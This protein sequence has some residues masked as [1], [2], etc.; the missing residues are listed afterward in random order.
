MQDKSTTHEEI[1]T[2]DVDAHIKPNGDIF[3][4]NHRYFGKDVDIVNLIDPEIKYDRKILHFKDGLHKIISCN[5]EKFRIPVPR[6]KPK[7]DFWGD[8]EEL[9]GEEKEE[10][11]GSREEKREEP[12][13]RE[14]NLR[15]AQQRVEQLVLLNDY[16]H[17]L[18]IT[19]NEGTDARNVKEV[20]RK[21]N[22][23]LRD[24]VLRYGLQ[25]VLI[26]EHHKD[27]RIHA[28]A[29]INDKLPLTDSG[30]R[31]VEG[32]KKPVK[33]ETIH[34]KCISEEKIRC[35]VYNVPSWKHGF[36]TAIPVYG[37]RLVLA[38]YITKYVTKGT[39]KIFGRYYWCSRNQEMYPATEY[40][41]LKPCEFWDLPQKEYWLKGTGE[42]FKYENHV[43]IQVGGASEYYNHVNE[44]LKHDWKVTDDE[45]AGTG[46][47]F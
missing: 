11:D 4:K 30:T 37:N 28:H 1:I 8:L 7:F 43:T 14:D 13:N 35:T 38:S 44:L 47:G 17:F 12:R 20:M 23:W 18:T 29:L 21:M 26:P 36:T 45:L 27:G 5:R 9:E 10:A 46:E 34:R 25:Y 16:T 19:F 31:M 6:N 40:D 33:V 32:Y 24:K 39:D 15:R 42:R 22:N 3:Y 41:R 2:L